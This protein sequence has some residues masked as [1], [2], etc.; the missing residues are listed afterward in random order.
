M[1]EF[2]INKFPACKVADIAGG[3]G[4]LTHLLNQS[5]FKSVVIDPWE[6]ELP[7][8]FKSLDGERIKIP[9]EKVPSIKKNF[10]PEMAEDFNLLLS[11]H[12]HGCMIKVLEASQKFKKNFTIVPC[13]VIDEPI[14][15][16]EGINW[17]NS[18]FDMAQ[19]I[20]LQPE[21]FYLN[22]VLPT[23]TNH[24]HTTTINYPKCNN[25][26]PE[27]RKTTGAEKKSTTPL[28]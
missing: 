24:W 3:H 10:E 5:G 7:Q 23:P 9:Q 13:C 1:A 20:D 18:L 25:T 22:L 26:V 4:L 6:L 17:T 28:S 12:G 15:K 27:Q 16:L 2:I 21:Y 8:K 14:K 11:L 19:K